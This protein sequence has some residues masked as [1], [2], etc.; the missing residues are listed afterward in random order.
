MDARGIL[1]CRSAD[2]LH[3]Y[4]VV[5]RQCRRH[6]DGLPR[7]AAA[8]AALGHRH[9]RRRRRDPAHRFRRRHRAADAAALSQAGRRRGAAVHR[10]QAARA[11]RSRQRRS[12]GGRAFVARGD[13]HRRCRY[14][15]EPRQRH[16]HR[17]HRAGQSFVARH[18]S[19]RLHSADHGRRRSDH[20]RCSIASRFSFGRARRFSAGSPAASLRP[21]R[22][23]QVI[24]RP[25]SARSLRTQVEFA[26]AGAAALLAIAAG[27][28]WQRLHEAKARADAVRARRVSRKA[29]THRRNE[30]RS[31]ASGDRRGSQ[32]CLRRIFRA[33]CSAIG[34][35]PS[36]RCCLADTIALDF[37]ASDF[38]QN[39][40]CGARRHLARDVQGLRPRLHRHL[41]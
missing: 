11:R 4:S 31:Y 25:L 17:G 10:R 2:H 37:S 13:D 30:F 7:P 19:R 12:R 1:V 27:G 29:H 6:C 40:A 20:S 33:C 38:P 8:A 16:R 3:Q 36:A 41:E 24:R 32:P 26:A 18:R 28:L 21:I 15:H 9:R 39:L 22:Q 34:F 35:W 23:W 14:R 5:R